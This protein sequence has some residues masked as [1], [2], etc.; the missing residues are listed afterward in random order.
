MKTLGFQ[1]MK[2]EDIY[3]RNRVVLI[4]LENCCSALGAKQY[5]MTILMLL[6]N[7]VAKEFLDYTRSTQS[8]PTVIQFNHAVY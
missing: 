4:N 5:Y 2:E 8:I 1:L 6:G 3:L 7:I